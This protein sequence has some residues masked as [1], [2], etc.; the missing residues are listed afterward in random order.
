MGVENDKNALAYFG[1]AYYVENQDVIKSVA[2]DN[3]EGP[4]VKPNQ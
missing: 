3:G 4:P 1:Y 2:I